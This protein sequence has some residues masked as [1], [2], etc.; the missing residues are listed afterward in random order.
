MGSKVLFNWGCSSLATQTLVLPSCCNCRSDQRHSFHWNRSHPT[1]PDYIEP[2]YFIDSLLNLETYLKGMPWVSLSCAL[3]VL[4]FNEPELRKYMNML[5][6]KVKDVYTKDL[7]KAL[8]VASVSMSSYELCSCSF[9]GCCSLGVL[10]SL[11][12]LYSFCV[13]FCGAP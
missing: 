13:L 9:K 7:V 5:I 6:L 10:H 1:A 8:C 11:W 4:P 2:S 3:C 12:L